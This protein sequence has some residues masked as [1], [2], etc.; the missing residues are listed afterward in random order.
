MKCIVYESGYKYQLK[1]PCVLTIE[2]FPDRPIE[3]EYVDLSTDGKLVIKKGYAWDGPSGPT[4]DTKSFMQGSLVHD[5]LYQLMRLNKLDHDQYR[6]TADRILQRIC[7][8][9]GMW[10]LRAWAVYHA[11]R[12]FGNPSADPASIWPTQYAPERCDRQ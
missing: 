9:D 2:I 3:T 8:E 12:V 1:E 11:V 10:S 5:A 4:I 6:E 7:K